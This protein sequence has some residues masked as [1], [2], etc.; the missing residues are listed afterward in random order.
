[1]LMRPAFHLASTRG[2]NARLSIFVFHRVLPTPDPL[3]PAEVDVAAFDRMLGWICRW[4]RVVPLAEGIDLMRRGDLPARAAA[5]TFDDGYADNLTHALPILQ[6]HGASAT[7]FVATGFLDGGRMWND[8]VIES[9]RRTPLA[10]LDLS[11]IGLGV[12]ATG[13]IAEKRQAIDYLIPRTKHLPADSR[14]AQVAAIANASQAMLPDDLMMRS[15]QLQAWHRAGMG[16]GAHTVTHPILATTE[17]DSARQE[18]ADSKTQLEALL[19]ERIGLFA[20]PNGKPEQDYR[21]EHARLAAELGFDAAVATVWGAATRDSD[22]FQ[23][24]RFTP[25]DR[26]KYRFGLRLLQNLL[27]S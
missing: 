1:M 18:M 7:L 11:A 6:R 4:F 23:L 2:G 3:F 22:V 10:Q 14:Q 17:L 25:W 20:Y 16:V 19:G 26:T 12:I 9:V 13:T 21:S 24:P 5:I 27:S 8:T 15:D